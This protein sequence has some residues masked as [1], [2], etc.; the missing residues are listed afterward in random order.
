MTPILLLTAALAADTGSAE[1]VLV[2]TESRPVRIRLHLTIEGRPFDRAWD[3]YLD[4]LFDALDADRDGSLTSKELRCALHPQQFLQILQGASAI[5][6]APAPE[7][8]E[9]ARAPGASSATRQDFKD[10][11]RRAGVGPLHV[12]V[13]TRQGKADPLSELLWRH[14]DQDKD[15]KLS[16][17]E[18]EA[19]PE[20]LHK[21]DRDD[22]E[23]VSLPELLPFGGAPGYV[24]RPYLLG[25]HSRVESAA[26]PFVHVGPDD[27]PAGLARKALARFDKDGDGKLG[28]GEAALG[29]KDGLSADDLTKWFEGPPDLEADVAF[30]RDDGGDVVA[31]RPGTKPS[32]PLVKVRGG[33]AALA[34]RGSQVALLPGFPVPPPREVARRGARELF[35]KA[36]QN[37]DEF[38][39][40]REV[41][42]PPFEFVSLMRVA[43]TDGDDR[44]AKKEVEAFLELQAK[45]LAGSVLLSVADRGRTL[46]EVIDADQDGR[47]GRR[48]LRSAWDAVAAWDRDG[49]GRLGRDEVPQQIHLAVSHARPR[50][51]ERAVEAPGYGAAQK[52]PQRAQG[53]VW[54]RK[55]DRNGDGDVSPREFLGTAEQ[56]RRLDADGD[57][58]LSPEEADRAGNK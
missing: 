29:D 22:D 31:A 33:G 10:Y 21:F 35:A 19:A 24:F 13:G 57:G 28:R 14:L 23:S 45:A 30:A 18:L 5:D 37:K 16:R 54:F 1:D 34:L 27:T 58:L 55:M 43:D 25:P 3:A 4:T 53:P 26:S 2:F 40:G 8:R 17:Q 52:P 12:E 6:P 47:L 46:F 38:L 20:T 50:A 36:D 49:D 32:A 48:D 11:Y 42:A 44:L 41:Y 9:L 7:F 15:G 56:F 51:G 39:D